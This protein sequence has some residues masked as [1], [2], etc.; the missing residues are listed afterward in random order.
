[1]NFVLIS[2][3]FGIVQC[4]LWSAFPKWFT[5]FMFSIPLLAIMANGIGSMLIVM[6]AG[7]SA[8]IGAANLTGSVIF[9]IWVMTMT[10]GENEKETRF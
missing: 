2:L 10:G 7:R 8:F 5:R 3:V 1:M 6:I 4:A 9:A